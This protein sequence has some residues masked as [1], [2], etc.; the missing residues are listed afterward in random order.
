MGHVIYIMKMGGTM[1]IDIKWLHIVI[2][3]PA[4]MIL[5]ILCDWTN[6]KNRFSG[7]FHRDKWGVH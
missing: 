6:S 4:K 5:S 1:F 2:N 3:Y 7:S